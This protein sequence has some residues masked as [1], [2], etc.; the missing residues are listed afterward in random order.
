MTNLPFGSFRLPSAS[1][2]K[3]PFR[4]LWAEKEK[5]IVRFLSTVPY[6]LYGVGLQ[7]AKE[8]I[9]MIDNNG[10]SATVDP[11]PWLESGSSSFATM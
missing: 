2:P 4:K 11:R 10:V 5:E 8:N 1:D 7:T 3:P 9:I 6:G